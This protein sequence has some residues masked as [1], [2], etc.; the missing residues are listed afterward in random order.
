ME[1]NDTLEIHR[2]LSLYGHIVDERE[3][4]RMA[5]LFTADLVFDAQDF[6][7]EVTHGIPAL[8]HL[9]ETT[10]KHPLAHHATNIVITEAA[11]GTV[12]VISKGIGVGRKGLVGSVVYRDIV[13]KEAQGWRI[14]HRVA[15]RRRAA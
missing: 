2:V 10:D 11:D 7:S 6:G 1:V 3:W 5:E 14:A 9:W 4:D 13:R 8:R 15:T 12:R